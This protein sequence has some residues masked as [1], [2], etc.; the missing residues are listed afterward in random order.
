MS[1]LPCFVASLGLLF[2]LSP[3]AAQQTYEFRGGSWWNGSSFEPRA[4]YS[5]E[6]TFSSRRPAQVDSVI[7]LSGMFVVPPYGEAH[8]HTV[9]YVPSRT[10]DLLKDGVFYALIL[11]VGREA[12][13]RSVTWFNRRNSLDVNFAAAGVTAPDGHPMQIMARRGATAEELDGDWVTTVETEDD[14]E[15]K[16][17]ALR[18]ANPDVIKVFLLYSEQY[19]ERR[20]NPDIPAR[21]RGMEPSLVPSIV[22]R[23]HREG[24]RVA[25]HVRTAHDFHVAVEAGVDIVAH[26]P[27]FSMGPSSQADLDDPDRMAD[28][29]HPEWFRIDPRDAERAAQAGITVVP[30]I[31][32]VDPV[33]EGPDSL[34]ESARRLLDRLVTVRREVLTANL[35]LLKDHGVTLAA[36]S[37]AGEGSPVTEVLELERLGVFS[38]A[39]LLNMLTRGAAHVIFPGRSLGRLEAGFEASFLALAADP[40]Q[41][42]DN[43][44]SIRLRFKQGAPLD[45]EAVERIAAEQVPAS[46]TRTTR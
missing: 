44:R 21:Y 41:R 35:R 22:R 8:T 10:V 1:S 12:I 20:G 7:D 39:E 45:L 29:E 5:V 25:A 4:M 18:E 32:R 6:N 37:D 3:L 27:G 19:R 36:G 30:T 16:W 9:A 2:S 26:L 15:A 28:I 43:L 33:G 42:L 31:G 23:A 11:N 46:T 38:R 40:T 34:P 17:P 13:G 24:L 14:L